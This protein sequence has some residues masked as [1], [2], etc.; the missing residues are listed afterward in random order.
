[1]IDLKGRDVLTSNEWTKEEL[2]QVLDG[3]KP[4]LCDWVRGLVAA[5]SDQ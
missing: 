2:D 5:T 1:M 4:V 3:K